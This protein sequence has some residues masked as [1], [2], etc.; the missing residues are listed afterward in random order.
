MPSCFGDMTPTRSTD[1][2]GFSTT[3]SAGNTNT[4]G[5]STTGA[6]Q[7]VQDA[8]QQN[9]N[10]ARSILNGGFQ[11]YGGEMTA[12]LSGN[13]R[14]A[15]N[16]IASAADTKNPYAA[17]AAT[18][19]TNYGAAPGFNYNFNTVADQHGPLGTT[20][21]YMNPYLD[22][23][24]APQLRQLALSGTQARQ[25]IN[26]NATQSGAYGDARHGVVESEQ[27]K[28]EAVQG[29]DLVGS[30]YGTAYDKAM[31]QREQDAGRQFSTQQAQEG[32]DKSLLERLRTSGID[33]T[34]LDKYGVSRDL[35]LASALGQTGATERGVQQA[36]DTA[37]F[38]EFLRGQGWNNQQLQFLTQLLATTP[39]ERQTT[40][41]GNVGTTNNQATFG[42]QNQTVSQPNNSGWQAIGTL[43]SALFL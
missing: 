13:E 9:Y 14:T 40:N 1:S 5:T 32:A 2:G 15:S 43:A 6:P 10:Q 28:N 33:L 18:D 38:N 12:P 26:A 34:N 11:S 4:T 31:Q 29:T 23:V 41:T 36:G 17:T 24:L 22:A 3:A 30:A 16:L 21:N 25:G 37:N 35:G 20:Q 39:T 19:F 8:G 7:W 27:R 42:Q